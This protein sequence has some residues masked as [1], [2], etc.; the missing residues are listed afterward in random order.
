MRV[1]LATPDVPAGAAGTPVEQIIAAV[2]SH[3]AANRSD[4]AGLEYGPDLVAWGKARKAKM[5]TSSRR[6]RGARASHTRRCK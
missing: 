3:I 5:G 2:W 6:A 1:A 4:S